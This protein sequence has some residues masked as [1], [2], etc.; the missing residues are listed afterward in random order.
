MRLRQSTLQ[1]KAVLLSLALV[2]FGLL[3]C[4][5][6][7]GV[8]LK[9]KHAAVA[10][11]EEAGGWGYSYDQVTA[12]AAEKEAT[13]KCDT[14]KVHLTWNKGCGALAQSKEDKRVLAAETGI[15]R[16]T[17]EMKAKKACKEKGAGSCKVV[18]WA[19]NGK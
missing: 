15:S 7:K 11:D 5:V 18:V 3:G 10:Y 6:V 19:C 14:C 4:D 17:A 12:K 1:T 9:E 8:A 16:G 2:A 13:K